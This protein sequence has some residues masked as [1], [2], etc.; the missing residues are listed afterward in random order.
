MKKANRF[1][2]RPVWMAIASALI[3]FTIVLFV[4]PAGRT[5]AQG[6]LGRFVEV[7]SPWDLIRGAPD[8]QTTDRGTEGASGAPGGAI[9]SAADPLGEVD[10]AVGAAGS[11]SAPEG[12][13]PPPLPAGLDAAQ[14]L[15]SLEEAQ[16][17]CP[18]TIAV[19]TKLPNGYT[20]K[21]VL[22]PPTPP[23]MDNPL[24]ANELPAFVALVFENKAGDT[25]TLTEARLPI[26]VEMPI[27]KDSAQ[28]VTVNGQEGLYLK[29]AWTPEG[30]DADA[31][32]HQLHWQGKDGLSY[33]LMSNQ[34]GLEELLQ[35]AESIQ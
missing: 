20:L 15:V 26:A 35:I 30:W 8:A 23:E 32:Q 21:G 31:N 19:P 7:D 3:V 29:G 1:K 22:S 18:F 33:D 28:E 16:A 2:M 5:I 24:P 14:P 17:A 10:P 13:A 12:I 34:L 6:L 11:V 9:D 27:G 25:L 4:T